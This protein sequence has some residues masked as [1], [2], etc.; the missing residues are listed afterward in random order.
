MICTEKYSRFSMEIETQ[1]EFFL[2]HCSHYTK[3]LIF[4]P[5]TQQK[6]NTLNSR[7]KKYIYINK[8]KAV[9][10]YAVMPCLK[11]D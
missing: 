1:R 11:V 10:S 3:L 4:Y 9:S 6:L 8:I 5:A 7:W 2:S